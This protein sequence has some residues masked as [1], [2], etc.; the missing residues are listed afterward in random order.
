MRLAILAAVALAVA[1]PAAAAP[2]DDLHR[3]MD[4]HYRW[5]LRENPTAATALGIRDYDGRIRDIS[6]AARDRRVREAQAFLGR[7][8]AIPADAL[9]AG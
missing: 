8:Q 1:A 3:L 2:A 9:P 4:E 6:P 7:L 5:L